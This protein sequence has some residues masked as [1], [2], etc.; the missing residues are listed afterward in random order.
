MLQL[1][2]VVV[3]LTPLPLGSV[4]PWSW[5]LLAVGIGA[6]LGMWC[7]RLL[8]RKAALA[9][10][11]TA[12]WPTV[13]PF[14]LVVGWIIVQLLPITPEAWHHS[15]WLWPASAF[16]AA[17]SSRITVDPA[18]TIAALTRLITYGAIFWLALQYG[19]DRRAA[20]MMFKAVVLAAVGFSL[21]GLVVELS[22]IRMV[23]WF[24][25]VTAIQD[26]SST[27]VNRN[28][29]ATYA[30]LALVCVSGLIL[31]RVDGRMANT[32]DFTDSVDRG[33]DAIIARN[34]F[35]IAGWLL[36][37]SALLLTHSL[38]GIFSSGVA[39]ASLVALYAHARGA[40]PGVI[41]GLAIGAGVLLGAAVVA[42]S[43][44]WQARFDQALWSQPDDRGKLALLALQGIEERPLLGSGYGTFETFFTHR[45][46]PDMEARYTKAHNA[47][48]ENAVE[49]GLPATAALVAIF[50]SI[51]V[52]TWRGARRRRRDAIYPCIGFSATVLVGVHSLL[53]FSLQI[54]AVTATYCLIAGIAC[55]QAD[56]SLPTADRRGRGTQPDGQPHYPR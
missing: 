56:P 25:K 31:A 36:I 2:V 17:P 28:T 14:L 41:F 24:P 47:Y 8:A 51:A 29:F 20:K 19:R 10:P 32:D 53:D 23:L 33:I 12:V 54:P 21:Y 13:L 46:P 1:F 16:N 48:L 40:R 38:G 15:A 3:L 22:E 42:G 35:L 55:A 30:G 6:L 9:V 49:L 18:E 11:L 43:A 26:L 52:R 39:L 37:A 4:Y 50:V 34:S 44:G 7:L 45:R 27:F 5:G